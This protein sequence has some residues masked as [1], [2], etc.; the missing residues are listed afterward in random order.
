METKRKPAYAG[1][2]YP[3]D[4][5]TLR[6]TVQSFL[7]EEGSPMDA[8]AVVVPHAGYVYSGSVTGKVLSA[9]RLPKRIILLGPNHT[10]W[11]T[12][13]SLAPENAWETPIGTVPIDS[14]LN[15]KLIELC[16]ELEEDSDAHV[17]EHCLE[18]Q[19]PFIRMLQPDCRISA[20]C[21]GTAEY[22]TLESLGHAM[23]EAVRSLNEPVLL[24]S[25]SDMTHY[26]SADSA[27]RKDKLAIDCI[28]RIDP[29]GLY[30]T[31][32]ENNISMCGFAPTVSI[33]TACLDLGSSDGHLIDYTNSGGASGDFSSVVAYAG[34]IIR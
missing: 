18:V 4:P 32:V 2:F 8:K 11:G 15:R 33:L 7:R 30:K 19:L 9:V 26:E 25:S 24:L 28:L 22:E 12:A 1:Q 3:E 13:L 14:E 29:H 10:G 21:L 16:P 20:V 34:I 5:E 31:I 27:A 23:A 6:R 17:K